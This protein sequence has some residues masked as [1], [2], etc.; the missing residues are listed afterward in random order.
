MSPIQSKPEVL[1]IDDE[2]Q[3]RRLLRFT[4]EDAGYEVMISDLVDRGIATKDGELQQVG[5]FMLSVAAGSEGV[6]IATNPP[7]DDLANAFAAHALREH[8]PRKMALLLNWNFAAGFD[9]PHRVFV[10]D[11][12]PPSRIYLFKRRLPMMHRDGWTG[13]RASS[14]QAFAWFVWNRAHVGP[15]ELRRV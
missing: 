8:K 3:L 4:L 15:T 12:C 2:V 5:D 11:E 13:A 6:D 7:Y 9:D 14:A 1:V 10:M